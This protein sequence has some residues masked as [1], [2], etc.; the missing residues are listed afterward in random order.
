MPPSFPDLV[1]IT[2]LVTSESDTSDDDTRSTNFVDLVDT[3]PIKGEIASRFSVKQMP[4]Q[5]IKEQN[6]LLGMLQ[7]NSTAKQSPA[8]QQSVSLLGW[9]RYSKYTP[10]TRID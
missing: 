7:R 2:D 5:R 3:T 8:Q 4:N 10:H 9:Y 1:D 6:Q